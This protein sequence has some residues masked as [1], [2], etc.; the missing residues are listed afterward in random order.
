MKI[1][2][3]WVLKLLFTIIETY[4]LTMIRFALIINLINQRFK[5]IQIKISTSNLNYN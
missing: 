2:T 4:I 3:Y 1:I 5:F